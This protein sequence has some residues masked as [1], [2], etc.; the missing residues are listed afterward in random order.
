MILDD[1]GSEEAVELRAELGVHDPDLFQ[2][3]EQIQKLL[4][5][6]QPVIS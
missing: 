6:L 4:E 1:N 3:N 5:S 2:Q